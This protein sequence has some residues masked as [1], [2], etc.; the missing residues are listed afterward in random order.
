MKNPRENSPNLSDELSLGWSF[1][2]RSSQ[3]EEQLFFLLIHR[4]FLLIVQHLPNIN[5]TQQ[6]RLT[7]LES[8]HGSI[9]STFRSLRQA[10]SAWAG[11]VPYQSFPHDVLQDAPQH[12]LP[13]APLSTSS[14]RIFHQFAH[15]IYPLYFCL[16]VIGSFGKFFV[17]HLLRTLT[18]KSCMSRPSG[19]S[20]RFAP[21][22]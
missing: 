14:L 21:L 3:N 15:G 4:P 22:T 5:A 6:M 18:E 2:Q 13:H 1:E 10:H 7:T 17:I 20:S 11:I 8:P 16:K 19:V 9:R 12:V